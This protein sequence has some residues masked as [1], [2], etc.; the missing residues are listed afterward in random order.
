MTTIHKYIWVA[1]LHHDHV[2]SSLHRRLRAS[3]GLK[4]LQTEAAKPKGPNEE[5]LK[6]RAEEESAAKAEELAERV[7]Q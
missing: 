7:K 1:S 6:R 3:L 5:E 4:P 2:L